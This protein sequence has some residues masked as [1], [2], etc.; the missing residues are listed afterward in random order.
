M[1]IQLIPYGEEIGIKIDNKIDFYLKTELSVESNES[2]TIIM[3]N[4][5]IEVLS[6]NTVDFL[7]PEE[8]SIK[9]L[10]VLI[11]DML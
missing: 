6:A 8:S 4:K 10:V 3:K 9:D 1:R 5:D 7:E 11:K 2:G